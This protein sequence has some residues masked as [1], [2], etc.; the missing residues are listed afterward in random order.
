M[1]FRY[2]YKNFFISSASSSSI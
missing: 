2:L 1:T